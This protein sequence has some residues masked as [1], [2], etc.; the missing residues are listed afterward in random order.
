MPALLGDP[1]FESISDVGAP[2]LLE[3]DPL[4]ELLDNPLSEPEPSIFF[5]YVSD[6][7]LSTISNGGLV[8][9]EG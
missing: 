1:L 3:A 8:E 7:Y 5:R 4:S 6:E 9:P 2:A